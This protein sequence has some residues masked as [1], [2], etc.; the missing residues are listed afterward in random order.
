M[1]NIK[2]FVEYSKVYEIFGGLF[3]KGKKETPKNWKE[4]WIS[5]IIF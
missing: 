1:K 2:T 5:E 3:G 4:L